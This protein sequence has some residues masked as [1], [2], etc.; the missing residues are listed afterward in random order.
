MQ[1]STTGKV[2]LNKEGNQRIKEIRDNTQITNNATINLKDIRPTTN[3]TRP[4]N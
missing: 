4:T 2:K 3:I 1:P